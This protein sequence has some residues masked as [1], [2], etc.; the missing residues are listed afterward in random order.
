MFRRTQLLEICGGLACV[1]LL[2]LEL[3]GWEWEF[4]LPTAPP[5]SLSM[6]GRGQTKSDLPILRLDVGRKISMLQNQ[7]LYM[8]WCG[9]NTVEEQLKFQA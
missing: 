5:V 6:K 7:I 2:F 3:C 4:E 1:S 8:W 9:G